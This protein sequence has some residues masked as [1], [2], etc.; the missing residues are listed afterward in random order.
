LSGDS[1]PLQTS[2]FANSKNIER[3]TM[4]KTNLILTSAFWVG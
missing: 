1:S 4:R 3:I 2:I